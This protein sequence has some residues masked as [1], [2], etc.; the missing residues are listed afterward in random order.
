M[1]VS[2]ANRPHS[3]PDG[4]ATTESMSTLEPS[5]PLAGG[6]NDPPGIPLLADQDTTRTMVDTGR[7]NLF[8]ATNRLPI[9][10][11]QNGTADH[12]TVAVS[13]TISDAMRVRGRKMRQ[14]VRPR[15]DDASSV[16]RIQV[17]MS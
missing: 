6:N 17:A 3:V 10:H 12:D 14:F 2:S 1:S 13:R 11:G 9:K 5:R 4:L 7:D 16:T 8:I 15:D